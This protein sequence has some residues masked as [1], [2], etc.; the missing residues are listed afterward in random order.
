[1]IILTTSLRL[2]SDP[3]KVFPREVF[4]DHLKKFGNFGLT[5]AIIILPLSLS[6]GDG[7]SHHLKKN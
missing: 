6:E 2:G 7:K 3:N 5:M 4:E 1:L